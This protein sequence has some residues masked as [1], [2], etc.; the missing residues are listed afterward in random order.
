MSKSV[1]VAEE[2]RILSEI[3]YLEA[4][5]PKDP[6]ERILLV[7]VIVVVE[8]LTEARAKVRDVLL[9]SVLGG[10]VGAEVVLRVP[11]TSLCVL[12]FLVE[13]N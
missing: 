9:D 7:E 5:K 3:V 11:I 4:C 10:E 12:G 1:A 13:A 6:Y 8:E 2:T